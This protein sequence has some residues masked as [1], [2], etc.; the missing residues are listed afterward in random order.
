VVRANLKGVFRTYKTLRDGTRNAYWY[1]RATGKRLRGEPGSPEF[2][3]DFA[4]AEQSMRD[5][6]GHGGT[7]NG[8]IREYTLSQEFQINLAP[9]TQVEYRRML[10]KAETTSAICLSLRSQI[11]G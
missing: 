2:I 5:R 4:N 3:S 11:G 9:S 6:L 8:L 1:H 7:L 10:T